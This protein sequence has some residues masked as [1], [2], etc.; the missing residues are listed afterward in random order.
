MCERL[1]G[2]KSYKNRRNKKERKKKI[3]REIEPGR[4]RLKGKNEKK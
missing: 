2:K 4:K 3:N 1:V